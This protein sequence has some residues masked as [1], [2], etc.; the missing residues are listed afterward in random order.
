MN[1][2]RSG[3]LHVRKSSFAIF[4]LLKYFIGIQTGGNFVT[5]AAEE[6]IYAKFR[7]AG[8]T[9]YESQA[10]AEEFEKGKKKFVDSSRAIELRVGSRG[11]TIESISVRR[12][13]LTLE[14]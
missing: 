5:K 6:F 3:P 1:F 11:T 7:Q 12:G 13:V 8:Y 10:V 2:E 14:G 9:D 4:H